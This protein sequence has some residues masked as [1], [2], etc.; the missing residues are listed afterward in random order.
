MRN[1]LPI[2]DLVWCHLNPVCSCHNFFSWALE[3]FGHFTIWL[4]LI[5]CLRLT[6]TPFPVKSVT[7]R[8]AYLTFVCTMTFS[9]AVGSYLAIVLV[10]AKHF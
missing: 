6:L 9:C 4:F 3:L 5:L 2:L 7:K 8:S 10:Y 1:N